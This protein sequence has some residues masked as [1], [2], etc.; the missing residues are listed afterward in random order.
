[1]SSWLSPTML[2]SHE[3]KTPLSSMHLLVDSLLEAGDFEPGKTRE[4]LELIARENLRLSWLIDNFLTFSRMDNKREK[5]IFADTKPEEV[6]QA[7]CEAVRERFQSSNC[8]IKVK[9]SP[10]LP[11]LH[12]DENALVT[13]LLNLFDNAYK[14]TPH[15]K[16]IELD[17]YNECGQV[18]FAVVDNGVGIPAREQKK[19]FRRFYQVNQQL[20][21]EVGGCG[22]G[23][24]IVDF[25]AKAHHGKVQVTSRPG[26][27]ST[28]IISVPFR[29]TAER[30]L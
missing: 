3:L 27:G 8:C 30:S 10:N 25:I 4:Y 5:F 22:L 11:S 12:A 16:R 17:A 29:G 7:A 1:M 13:A 26:A 19:V 24:S 2:V 15:E 18:C 23:L 20:S 9:I 6:I 21:R 28:F 14:F